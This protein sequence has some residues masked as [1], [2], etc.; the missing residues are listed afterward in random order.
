MIDLAWTG[1]NTLDFGLA[2]MFNP[3][4]EFLYKQECILENHPDH[5]C[6]QIECF[7][8]LH[9]TIGTSPRSK[10]VHGLKLVNKLQELSIQL[11][12]IQGD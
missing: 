10:K 6:G 8:A 7:N 1:L 5:H 12:E 11:L 3:E 2:Q 9:A 4:I